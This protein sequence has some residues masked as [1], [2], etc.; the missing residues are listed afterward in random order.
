MDD[1]KLYHPALRSYSENWIDQRS[2]IWSR[3]WYPASEQINWWGDIQLFGRPA[4]YQHVLDS[5]PGALVVNDG[6][7]RKIDPNW[8]GLDAYREQ[9]RK[10]LACFDET[11]QQIKPWLPLDSPV[12]KTAPPVEPKGTRLLRWMRRG[13]P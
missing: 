9:V 2:S 4:D 5:V 7:Q 1:P 6:L 3:W 8:D 11:G 12:D 10:W 13:K